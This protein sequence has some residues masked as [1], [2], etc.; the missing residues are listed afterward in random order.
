MVNTWSTHT[1]QDSSEVQI[2]HLHEPIKQDGVH[3][4]RIGGRWGVS[5][6]LG[7]DHEYAI[8]AQHINVAP[9]FA[10]SSQQHTQNRLI[11]L[12]FL[13]GAVLAAIACE[14]N[15]DLIDQHAHSGRA[16][17]VAKLPYSALVAQW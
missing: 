15:V 7:N 16:V 10:E 8:G 11:M 2:T 5:I 4:I 3:G 17:G 13:I 6:G 14:R 9:D 12:C 1:S